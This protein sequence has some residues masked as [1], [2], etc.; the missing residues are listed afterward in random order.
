MQEAQP[1]GRGEQPFA[2]EQRARSEPVHARGGV[3]ADPL[4][5][6][7]SVDLTLGPEEG[8]FQRLPSRQI[9]E[10]FQDQAEPVIAELDGSNGL[11]KLTVAVPP[12]LIG[13]VLPIVAVG[14]TLL[15]TKAKVTVV[16]PPS[17][18]LAVIVTVWL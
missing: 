13:P 4:D 15:T 1:H 9:A 12:S 14:A 17:P 10:A 2:R 7:Q 6:W 8:G 11:V 18:S 16:I 3:E 5:R